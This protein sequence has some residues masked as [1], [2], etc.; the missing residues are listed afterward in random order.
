VPDRIELTGES[1][2]RRL[3]DTRVSFAAPGLRGELSF[4]IK[5]APG[6]EPLRTRSGLRDSS[7]VLSNDEIDDAVEEVGNLEAYNLETEAPTPTAGRMD[8]TTRSGSGEIADDEALI[9]YEPKPGEYSYVIYRDEAG[10]ISLHFP[11]N[12]PQVESSTGETATTTRGTD[13]PQKYRIV[14]RKP[15][16]PA[17]PSTTESQTRFGVTTIG[18]KLIKLVVGKAIKKAVGPLVGAADYGAVWLWEN[19]ARAF[20]GFHSGQSLSDLLADNPISMSDSDWNFLQGGN[21]K[22]LLFVHGTTSTTSGAFGGLQEFPDAATSLYDLYQGRVLGFNHHTLTLSVAD[23]VADFYSA[24]PA[25]GTFHFDIVCHSRGGL[26]ARALKELSVADVAKLTKKEF[27]P[28]AKISIGKIVFVGTPN[29]GTQL[30]DPK[31]VPHALEVL[32]NVASLIPGAGLTLAGIFS[33]AAFVAQNG[34]KVL[35]G[36]RNM[37]PSDTFLKQLNEGTTGG[38]SSPINDYYAIQSSFSSANLA[39]KILLRGVKYLFKDNLNDLIVPTLGT[40]NID[41]IALTD[42]VVTYFGKAPKIESI[43]HTQY[44][45]HHETWAFIIDKLK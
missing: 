19:R 4:D 31:D 10:I 8:E 45:K 32:A 21:K 36:M 39:N 30:A 29:I 14:L 20:Q 26:V 16:A 25:N 15:Q 33:G 22:S 43:A 6:N 35:P 42:D 11:E 13:E 28:T 7:R 9:E 3:A 2:P 27:A 34:F 23:N 37:N 12:L 44:F 1:V 38:A 24:L 18:K 5:P 40:S 41:G 17:Q